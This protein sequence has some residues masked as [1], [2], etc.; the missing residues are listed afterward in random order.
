VTSPAR[1][2]FA[3]PVQGTPGKKRKGYG[4]ASTWVDASSAHQLP[5]AIK[6]QAMIV[7]P[8]VYSD[9]LVSS[10]TNPTVAWMESGVAFWHDAV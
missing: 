4:I 1:N 5:T 3:A 2:A 10:K 6:R 7:A 9:I 8:I